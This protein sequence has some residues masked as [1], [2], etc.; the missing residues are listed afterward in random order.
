MK[1]TITSPEIWGQPE[2]KRERLLFEAAYALANGDDTITIHFEA[3]MDD[4]EIARF[5]KHC[6]DPVITEV[7]TMPQ[8]YLSE[9]KAKLLGAH[10]GQKTSRAIRKYMLKKGMDVDTP[11][12]VRFADAINPL[13]PM[14][15]EYKLSTYENVHGRYVKFTNTCANAPFYTNWFA[16]GG[17]VGTYRQQKGE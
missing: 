13:R 12:Y 10:K 1:I 7:L 15:V 9:E 2:M 17:W 11:A 3:K 6:N 16:Y 14:D 5:I 8:Q 4:K